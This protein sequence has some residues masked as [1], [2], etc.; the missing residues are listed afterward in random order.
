MSATPYAS[1]PNT[2]HDRIASLVALG[3]G[4]LAVAHLVLF[5]L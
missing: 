1:D 2:P 4:V 3:L 5:V